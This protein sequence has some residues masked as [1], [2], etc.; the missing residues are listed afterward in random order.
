MP[1]EEM[2]SMQRLSFAAGSPVT[3]T[4]VYVTPSSPCT[5]SCESD[6]L[7]DVTDVFP[8]G[9]PVAV[10]CSRTIDGEPDSWQD[11]ALGGDGLIPWTEQIGGPADGLPGLYVRLPF[12]R[13]LGLQEAGG[14][15][16]APAAYIGPAGQRH[17]LTL[18]VQPLTEVVL[19]GV[20]FGLELAP[21]DVVAAP[22]DSLYAI[23]ALGPDGSRIEGDGVRLEVPAEA[24][25]GPYWLV[26]DGL[27]P[28][29]LFGDLASGPL[30]RP[31]AATRELRGLHPLDVG[32][33]TTFVERAERA[34]AR[35]SLRITCEGQPTHG[36]IDQSVG[37]R[38]PS[39]A[40]PQNGVN[41]V[42]PY[43]TATV[44]APNGRAVAQLT[45]VCSALCID[46]G[47]SEAAVSIGSLAHSGWLDEDLEAG[48]YAVVVH[49]E[50]GL[51][52]QAQV[53][54]DSMV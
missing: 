52:F 43:V 46:R 6:A 40:A 29:A 10:T 8:V 41:Q 20:P 18:T 23:H 11:C 42:G 19:P 22:V 54:F 50:A 7:S 30:P 2:A 53:A 15:L 26:V 1:T 21:G 14:Q 13:V 16:N 45:L 12:G 25:S 35:V 48:D 27:A 44:S 31:L 3:A 39:A 38:C 24:L 36:V 33:T 28:V 4:F 9:V 47:W 17:E 34:P 37:D 32:T 51:P 49:Q 5:G